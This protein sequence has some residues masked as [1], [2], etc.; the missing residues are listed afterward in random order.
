MNCMCGCG[1]EPRK[2]NQFVNTHDSTLTKRLVKAHK[3]G[4]SIRIYGV[5][6]NPAAYAKMVSKKFSNNFENVTK[7]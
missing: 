3:D 2:G 4:K 1:E 6:W 5:Y 7:K